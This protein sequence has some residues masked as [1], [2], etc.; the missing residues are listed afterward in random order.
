MRIPQVRCWMPLPGDAQEIKVYRK[1]VR[2]RDF[3]FSCGPEKPNPRNKNDFIK[4]M[5]S[6]HSY[7]K[8]IVLAAIPGKDREDL[9]GIFDLLDLDPQIVRI[10]K[11]LADN[12]RPCLQPNGQ[13]VEKHNGLCCPVA[14]ADFIREAVLKSFC[15]HN[16]K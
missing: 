14:N 12:C 6:L 15:F 2:L 16:S 10:H 1:F 9:V 5:K 4:E 8:T 7:I 3:R 11:I 13:L